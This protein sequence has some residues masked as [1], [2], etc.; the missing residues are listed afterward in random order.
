MI[1]TLKSGIYWSISKLKVFELLHKFTF[2][3]GWNTSVRVGRKILVKYG[4]GHWGEG[5]VGVVDNYHSNKQ[6][7]WKGVN[8]EKGR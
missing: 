5:A 2:V 3:I 7:I 8:K 6:I 1:I 4:K